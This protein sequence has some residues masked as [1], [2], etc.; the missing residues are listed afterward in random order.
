MFRLIL[1]AM[2]RNRLFKYLLRFAIL[3]VSAIVIT[4]YVLSKKEFSIEDFGI[5]FNKIRVL[6]DMCTLSVKDTAIQLNQ[7]NYKYKELS[8][9]SYNVDKYITIR[10]GLVGGEFD[11]YIIN[12]ESTL[13]IELDYTNLRKEYCILKS[14]ENLERKECTSISLDSAKAVIKKLEFAIDSF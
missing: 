4:N 3:I 11:H 14:N 7:F 1:E 5:K 6:R 9:Y 8:N 2:N 12:N 13:V 10:H